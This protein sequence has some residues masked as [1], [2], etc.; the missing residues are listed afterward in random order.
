MEPFEERGLGICGVVESH[1][2]AMSEDGLI[3]ATAAGY[4][5][6]L[7]FQTAQ[8]ALQVA[9]GATQQLARA[10]DSLSHLFTSGFRAASTACGGPGLSVSHYIFHLFLAGALP[11]D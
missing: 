5:P 6:V 7:S 10:G 4:A 2:G 1:L 8:E 3:P 9:V 11:K